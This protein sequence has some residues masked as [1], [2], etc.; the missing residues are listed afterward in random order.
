MNN[1][2]TFL[3][4]GSFGRVG[5]Q[6]FQIAA[7]IGYARKQNFDYI[8]PQW[9]CNYTNKYMS[10]Y[11]K[12]NI[13][14]QSVVSTRNTYQEQHFHHVDIPRMENVDLKGWFQ[15]KKYWENCEDEI[16]EYFEPHQT[17]VH[18]MY[19]KYGHLLGTENCAIHVR[20]GDYVGHEIHGVC[21]V[22][23]Y[24][25]AIEELK[26]RK[27]IQNFLLFS[28]DIQTARQMFPSNFNIIQ[29]NIDVED[30]FLMS[31]CKNF[32]IPNSSFSWWAAYLSK[33]NDKLIYAPDRW[34]ANPSYAIDNDI[35]NPNMIKINF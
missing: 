12:K 9:Q 11:F 7:T 26:K 20:L 25:R 34:F 18:R 22:N 24:N 5:N 14:Q 19:E 3:S 1:F 35:Y 21:N 15:S 29:N 27:D 4:L 8:F 17:V 23:Y 6:L 33:N 31:F 10:Q 32:I 13:P 2:A 28:D 30:L 16:R